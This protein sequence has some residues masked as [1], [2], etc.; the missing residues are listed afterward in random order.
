MLQVVVCITLT[1]Y[2]L[3]SMKCSVLASL[4]CEYCW[5]SAVASSGLVF[6]VVSRTMMIHKFH[7]DGVGGVLK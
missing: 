3:S 2:A 7:G 4:K 1:Q 6:E 5:T